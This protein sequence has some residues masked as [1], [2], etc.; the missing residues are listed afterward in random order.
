VIHTSLVL[1]LPLRTSIGVSLLLYPAVAG[2]LAR[3]DGLAL[4]LVVADAAPL[5]LLGM[6]LLLDRARL[7]WLD[8]AIPVL[9]VFPLGDVILGLAWGPPARPTLPEYLA[10]NV[11][12]GLIV[13]LVCGRGA[14]R[15][16]AVA[17]GLLLLYL[18]L[19]WGCHVFVLAWLH[20][21]CAPRLSIPALGITLADGLAFVAVAAVAGRGRAGHG[22]I[23][24]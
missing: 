8:E 19:R 1:N 7:G 3:T 5:A 16:A 11:G 20:G 10:L 17:F 6:V 13:G 23:D 9:P 14:G 18:L 22:S 12:L 21:H 2:L 15:R 4:E 24:R